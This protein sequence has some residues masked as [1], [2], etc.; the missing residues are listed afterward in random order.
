[1]TIIGYHTC[2]VPL[3]VVV[4]FYATFESETNVLNY[5]TYNKTIKIKYVYLTYG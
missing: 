4:E 5:V 1:M 3:F 2:P